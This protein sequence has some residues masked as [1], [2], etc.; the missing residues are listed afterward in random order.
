M[1]K[2]D[3]REFLEYLELLKDFKFIEA[4]CRDMLLLVGEEDFS[5]NYLLSIT[6]GCQKGFILINE[7]NREDLVFLITFQNYVYFS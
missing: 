5:Y 7:W 4:N 3:D 6:Q 2:K 1:T